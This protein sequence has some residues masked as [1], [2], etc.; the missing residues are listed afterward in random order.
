MNRQ[1]QP[2]LILLRATGHVFA[3]LEVSDVAE[4]DRDKFGVLQSEGG[5]TFR[6][7]RG[8]PWF[9]KFSEFSFLI[10]SQR[11]PENQ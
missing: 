11:I 2:H 10:N 1:P 3:E 8:K 7:S 9:L 5:V 6:T 4:G